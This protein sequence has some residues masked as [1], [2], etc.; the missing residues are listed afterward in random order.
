VRAHGLKGHVS[1]TTG[2]GRVILDDLDGSLRTRA[3]DGSLTAAG[4][5]DLLDVR[6]TDGRIDVT[7]RKGSRVREAWS[8]ES[9]DGSLTLRIPV[10]LAALLDAQTRDGRLR[11]D[12]PI[13]VGDRD[14]NALVGEL[15]GGGL[16]LRLR[17]QDGRITL[18]LSD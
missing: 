7:A 1:V 17:T 15:N 6:S 8:A 9:R 2:D 10:D 18:A 3:G 11:V 4:R 5:F 14:R 16:P 12:L 13:P